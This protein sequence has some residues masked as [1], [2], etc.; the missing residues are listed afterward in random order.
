MAARGM[1]RDGG[2][3]Y[4]HHEAAG[5]DGGSA[6]HHDERDCPFRLANTGAIGFLSTATAAAA[7]AVAVT[8]T[9]AVAAAAAVAAVTPLPPSVC[10]PLLPTAVLCFHLLLLVPP[11]PSLVRP[12]SSK[13]TY[14]RAYVSPSRVLLHSPPPTLFLSLPLV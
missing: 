14:T 10:H 5:D 9:S 2:G 1:K 8:T 6:G 7:A 3:E 13:A 11:K 12:T 4:R